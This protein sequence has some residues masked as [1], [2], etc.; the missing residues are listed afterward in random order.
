MEYTPS[1]NASLLSPAHYGGVIGGK[2]YNF[3]D[4]FIVSRIPEWLSDASFVCLLKEGSEDVDVKFQAHSATR[5][6]AI[7]V[8]DHPV[9]DG[10]YRD[11]I[12]KFSK[13]DREAPGTFTNFILACRGVS[14]KA[15]SLH[16]AVTRLQGASP[17][18]DS[19]EVIILATRRGIQ[20]SITDLK[21]DVD[22]KF[23]E[24]K[25]LLDTEIGDMTTDQRLCEQFV[26]SI[27]RLFPEWDKTG[28]VAL[29]AA[30]RD[31]AYLIHRSIGKTCTREQLLES[32]ASAISHTSPRLE[33]DGTLV[34]LYH[35]EDPAFDLSEKWDILLDWSQ[36]F[37]RS[38]RKVPTPAIWQ[39][40]LLPEL[41]DA[42]KHVR[43]TSSSKLI[44]FR[45]GACL[46]A[47]FALGWAFS[48]VQGY[49]FEVQQG[50]T[51]WNTGTPHA[52][53]THWVIS[54]ETELDRSSTRL[55]VELSQQTDVA[56]SVDAFLRTSGISCR[57]RLSFIPESGLGGRLDGA[58]AL[59][60]ANGA[61]KILRQAIDRYQCT[62]V[63]LFYAGPLGLAIFLG[64]LFNAMHASIQCYEQ[65]DDGTGYVPSCLLN[66]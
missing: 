5:R 17:T 48:E 23:L 19:T 38:T 37:S 36:H 16:H 1:Q 51:F 66:A 40:S 47:G 26:G 12:A 57:A 18:H 30:Y 7:Q 55:C 61:K 60:Y 64:R 32:I 49:S 2:G 58:A 56:R 52:P 20:E 59:N 42:Q 33:R 46:S 28:W 54:R 62:T 25:V 8:K 44:R 50:P 39:D 3:Q 53:G 13:L 4:A 63:D 29:A 14:E 24:D 35:W 21:L 34:R 11:V 15:K 43:A 9:K 41:Q 10:E 27:H 45:P 6:L 31:I 65:Q 22:L